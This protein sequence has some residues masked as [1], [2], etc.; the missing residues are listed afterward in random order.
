MD[1]SPCD[2]LMVPQHPLGRL[3][4]LFC[5]R[6]SEISVCITLLDLNMNTFLDVNTGN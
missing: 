4:A 5:T 6:G 3:K 2:Y 1:L